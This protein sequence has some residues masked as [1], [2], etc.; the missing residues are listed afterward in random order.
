MVVVEGIVAFFG[1]IVGTYER[2]SCIELLIVLPV[3]GVGAALV[4][5]VAVAAT[6]TAAV[7]EAVAV[8]VLLLLLSLYVAE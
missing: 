7:V 4:E 1:N 2:V 8:A 3:V 6:V 5:A